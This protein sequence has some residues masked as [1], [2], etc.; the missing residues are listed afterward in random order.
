MRNVYIL[1][2]LMFSRWCARWNFNGVL[3]ATARVY[4]EPRPCSEKKNGI[5]EERKTKKGSKQKKRIDEDHRDGPHVSW[6]SEYIY[7]SVDFKFLSQTIFYSSSDIPLLDSIFLFLCMTIIH[8]L[9]HSF[10]VIIHNLNANR[11]FALFINKYS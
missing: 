9:V 7:S 10:I 6:S 2:L 5:A 4:G 11:V 1:H 3:M 8:F